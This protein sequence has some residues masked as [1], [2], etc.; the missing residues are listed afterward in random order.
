MNGKTL[1]MALLYDFYGEL[2]TA[3]QQ[4]CFDLYFNEDF[5]L[6][7]IAENKGISRQGVRD[8]LVRAEAV[9]TD[10][11]AKIG[12]VSRFSRI[13]DIV[14]SMERDIDTLDEE[15]AEKLRGKIQ[16]LKGLI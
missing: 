5:S 1:E 11:E 10:Y 14:S 13:R 6:A 7:E 16:D 9:L 3:K 2:L 8:I 12:L 4:E 15:K